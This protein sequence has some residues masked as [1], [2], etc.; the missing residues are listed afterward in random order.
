VFASIVGTM[1]LLPTSARRLVK[2]FIINK[3]RG[4]VTLLRPGLDFLEKRFSLPVLGVIPY[5]RDIRI[6]QEDSVYLDENHETGRKGHLDIAIIRF[7]HIANYDDFDPLARYSKLRYVNRVAELGNPDLI[8][9]PGTKSTIAD[10]RHIVK[11]GLA[12]LVSKKSREGTPVIGICGGFQ[13]LGK[14]ISDPY[15][16]E[17]EIGEAQGLGLLDIQTVFQ[18]RKT[19]NQVQARVTD[20]NGL[21][22]G[23]KGTTVKGYEIHMGKTVEATDFACFRIFADQR[24]RRSYADGAVNKKGTVFGTYFHGVFHNAGFTR[25]LIKNLCE[26]RSV[27]FAE[28]AQVNSDEIYDDLAQVVRKHLDM[29]KVYEIIFRGE[30]GGKRL[31]GLD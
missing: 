26:L 5:I 24:G 22:H 10:L 19:T 29:A 21:L 2:G 16:V 25:Q 13:M 8:I 11:N 7:P 15:G 27:P 12:A 14:T 3:F 18:R 31:Q 28:T 30:H 1:Q 6:A 4:D 23:M 9:I 20:D 17:S